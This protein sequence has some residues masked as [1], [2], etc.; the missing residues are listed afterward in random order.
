MPGPLSLDCKL[1]MLARTRGH[2]RCR[3][4]IVASY[5]RLGEHAA[6]WLALGLAGA[7]LDADRRGRWLRGAGVVASSYVVNYAVKIVVRRHRPQ[8]D[9][10]PPLSKVCTHKDS[11]L[12]V[13]GV[14]MDDD[15]WKSVKP[16][17]EEK[18][19]NYPIV[20]GNEALA[21]KYGA[22]HNMPVSVL[23]DRDGKIADSHA[24]VVERDNWE[25]KIEKL[26]QETP[27]P[28]SR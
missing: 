20:I 14:S 24:G 16:F 6:C 18:K 1:L 4:R 12:V 2:S 23:I 10:L 8:L 5:S 28:T 26:L 13:I 9:G 22:L 19:L 15:G 27:Q 3:E 11:G 17:V 7:A 25:E 21:S